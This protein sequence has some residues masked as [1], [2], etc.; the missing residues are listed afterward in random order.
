M[1]RSARRHKAPCAERL[2]KTRRSNPFAAVIPQSGPSNERRKAAAVYAPNRGP[3]RASGGGRYVTGRGSREITQQRRPGERDARTRV[4]GGGRRCRSRHLARSAPLR[5]RCNRQ[6]IDPR[7]RALARGARHRS[8]HTL[9]RRS[10]APP[11]RAPGLEVKVSDRFAP[12]SSSSSPRSM[13]RTFP[14]SRGPSSCFI[15]DT[16]RPSSSQASRITSNGRS[17][18]NV[19]RLNVRATRMNSDRAIKFR[20]ST[21]HLAGSKCANVRD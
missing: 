1:E 17:D 19:K 4:L 16:S 21:V 7:P 12:G 18:A 15:H 10:P 3:L 8:V 2:K 9:T 6:R 5:R 13:T 11:S 20:G 14:L